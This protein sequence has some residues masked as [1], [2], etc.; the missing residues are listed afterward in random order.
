MVTINWCLK[1]SKGIKL[2]EPNENLAK[3]YIEMAK[4]S[5]N[6]MNNEKGKSLRWTIT[7]CYYSMYYSLCA[8]LTKIGIKCEIHTCSL[9]FMKRFLLDFYN[10]EDL[11]T[12]TKAFDLRN[13]IQYYA[14][15]IIDKEESNEIILKAPL[16]FNKSQ[17][18]LSRINQNDIDKI[19]NRL[20][21]K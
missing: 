1:Q 8:I 14:E 2:V 3:T 20:E 19:R 13:T 7:P 16:F 5:L 18:I 11:D 21:K 12:I 6:A 4:D 15:K 9:E 17:D 10:K